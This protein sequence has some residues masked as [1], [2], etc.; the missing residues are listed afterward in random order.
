VPKMP[1]TSSTLRS[2]GLSAT[3]CDASASMATSPPSPAL[4]ARSTSSTYL[5][6]T[7]M[8]SVQ[9]NIDRMP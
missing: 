9:K 1:T 7:M 4:S 6:E 8:V 2:R 3:A 5:N